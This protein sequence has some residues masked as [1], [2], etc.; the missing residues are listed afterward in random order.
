MENGCQSKTIKLCYDDVMRE[1]VY[2]WN[3]EK[4]KTKI[5]INI[6]AVIQILLLN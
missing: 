6:N 3:N 1:P 5:K 2:S 4:T